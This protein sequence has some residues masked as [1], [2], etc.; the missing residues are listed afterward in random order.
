MERGGGGCRQRQRMVVRPAIRTKAAHKQVRAH[1]NKQI[2]KHG[3]HQK[4]KNWGRACVWQGRGREG[5]MD[6]LTKSCSFFQ[7]HSIT[8][9]QHRSMQACTGMCRFWETPLVFL[10]TKRCDTCAWAR[11]HTPTHMHTLLV[12]WQEMKAA[13]INYFLVKTPLKHPCKTQPNF[14]NTSLE[15]FGVQH[16]YYTVHYMV[17]WYLGT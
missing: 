12:K 9:C 10:Q 6:G 13:S 5:G 11:T 17:W 8:H 15:L 1:L 14:P 4:Q 2:Y 3:A 7:L 16:N